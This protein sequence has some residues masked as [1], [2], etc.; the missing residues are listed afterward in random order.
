MDH[1]RLMKPYTVQ[2]YSWGVEGNGYEKLSRSVLNNP[3]YTKNGHM[4]WMTNSQFLGNNFLRKMDYET[5]N[6]WEN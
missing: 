5:L 4:I 2:A 6:V 3:P 1:I